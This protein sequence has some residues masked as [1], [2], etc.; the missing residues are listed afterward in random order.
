M[1]D[2]HF[3]HGAMEHHTPEQL[4]FH[5]PERKQGVS[6]LRGGAQRYALRQGLGW[7]DK[8]LYDMQSDAQFQHRVGEAY[9]N[10]QVVPSHRVRRAYEAMRDETNQQY[11]YLTKPRHQ[12]GLGVSVE[13]T[14]ED[15]YEHHHAMQQDILQNRRLKV[16]RTGTETSGQHPFFTNEEN[17]RFRAVHD[18][19]GHASIGRS[20]SRH[21]EEAAY[22]SH[23]QMYSPAAQ[24]ALLA[25]TRG[26][27]SAFIYKLGGQEFPEQKTVA[28]PPWAG[29]SR[30][31]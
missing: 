3:V 2:A 19:F 14:D 13:Y 21:G 16:F 4:S 8:G 26:Q 24:P 1:R 5:F 12:G 6:F 10:A 27:N 22:H 7:S 23:K 17:D 31:R 25:E 30:Q 15:P 11:E 9:Q 20:F 28:L 29:K 18:A